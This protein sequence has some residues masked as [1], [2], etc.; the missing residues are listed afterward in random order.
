MTNSTN[1]VSQA[2]TLN[3][4]KRQNAILAG[5]RIS[6]ISTLVRP[7]MTPKLSAAK[8]EMSSP[9]ERE[10]FVALLRA[11]VQLGIHHVQFNVVNRETLLAAK[12]HPEQFRNLTIRV[13][14]YT[15]YFVELADDLQ[16]EIIA[17]TSFG[18]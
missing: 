14:G 4:R 7:P 8:R 3:A 12:A 5:S 15:A 16:D 11:F 13:A 6:L 9:E 10:K 17:R 18:V 2:F 1:V